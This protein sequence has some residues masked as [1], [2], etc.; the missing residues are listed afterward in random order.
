MEH[1]PSEGKR[2]GLGK[3]GNGREG[4]LIEFEKVSVAVTM[5]AVTML[6]KKMSQ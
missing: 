1:D 6:K 2:S 5:K 3:I 4:E